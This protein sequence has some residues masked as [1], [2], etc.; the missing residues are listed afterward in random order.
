MKILF[1]GTPKF[2]EIVLS[3]LL[4]SRHKVVGVVCQPDK[5]AGRGNKMKSPHIV[6]MAREKGLPV[7]QFEKLSQHIEDFKKIGADVGVTA[8]YG[9][10]IPKTLLDILPIVNVHPSMLPKYRGSTPI[11]SALLN[12]DEVTGVSIM[13]TD[14]GMDDGD[15]YVQSQCEI[16]PED[17]Y[18]SLHDKL[19]EMGSE[20]LLETLDKIEH[21]DAILKPQDNSKATYV[22]LI[23]KE[24]G[25]LDFSDGA[26]KLV[27]KVR[28][29]AESPVAYLFVDGK[30]IKVHKAR[31]LTIN[32]EQLTIL[33]RSA[34]G[35]E[36]KSHNVPIGT[37]IPNKK[38]F[39]I[40]AKGGVF[41][42]L[43]CQAEGGKVMDASAFLNGFRFKS[44]KVNA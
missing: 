8:S 43:K 36:E 25:L 5:V 23:Q 10:I 28:A 14:V 38:R 13:K 9:K 44:G 27:D 4:E 18:F 41:E 16:L 17:D 32:N 26:K 30:R 31:Q 1:F 19:A 37:I 33:E 22:K 42:I 20:L 3:H 34:L 21:H 24:D 6:D 11:Q 2:A 40:Q 15:I 35:V 39:L 7:Y 12:G 29:F